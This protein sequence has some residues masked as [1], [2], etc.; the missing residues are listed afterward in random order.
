MALNSP[1]IQAIG[2]N[3]KHI[4]N[5]ETIFNLVCIVPLLNIMKNLIKLVQTQDVFV[6]DLVQN[7]QIGPNKI[8]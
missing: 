2:F 8:T 6:I 1:A 7:N 5:F 4:T 3:L